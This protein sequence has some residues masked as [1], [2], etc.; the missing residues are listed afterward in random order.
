MTC[1]VIRDLIPMYI[2]NTASDETEVAVMEHLSKC[3]ECRRYCDACRKAERKAEQLS[4]ASLK[5]AVKDAGGDIGGID[6]K[7]AILS[8]KLKLRKIRQTLIAV[9]LLLGMA[10]YVTVDIINTIKR[11]ERGWR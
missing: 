4:R 10:V 7:Y 5:K 2:D 3:E 1:E 9:F 11:K 6:Q 8:R